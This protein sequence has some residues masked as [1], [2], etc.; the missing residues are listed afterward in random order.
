LTDHLGRFHHVDSLNAS[1]VL[2]RQK[3]DDRHSVNLVL[4][5]GLEIGL[6]AGTTGGSEP[7][8]ESAVWITGAAFILL[9]NH[10]AIGVFNHGKKFHSDALIEDLFEKLDEL[11]RGNAGGQ[12]YGGPGLRRMEKERRKSP[13]PVLERDAFSRRPD[14]GLILTLILSFNISR[15]SGEDNTSFS[16]LRQ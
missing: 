10:A 8:M 9:G 16:N 11:L 4:M 12:L 1:R 2:D 6:N 5:E 15:T 14:S 13:D 3:R 7:A